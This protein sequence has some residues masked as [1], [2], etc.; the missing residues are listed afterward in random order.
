[1]LK[2]MIL[3]LLSVFSGLFYQRLPRQSAANFSFNLYE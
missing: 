1:L 2:K 3:H